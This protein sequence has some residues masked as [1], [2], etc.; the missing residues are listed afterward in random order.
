LG[1]SP[2]RRRSR[3]RQRVPSVARNRAAFGRAR[4]GETDCPLSHALLRPRSTSR[5][6]TWWFVGGRGFVPT[7][8]PLASQHEEPQVRAVVTSPL[9]HCTKC[10]VT[11]ISPGRW[12]N[13]ARWSWGE[14]NPRP[15]AGERTRYDHSR[16]RGCRSLTGGSVGHLTLGSGG[17]RPVF[18]W[19]QPSFRPSVV[20]PTVIS[21]FCCRAAGDRPRVALLLTMSLRS[22]EIQAARANCSLAILFGAPFYESE[23]LG[24]HAR[25]ALLTSKPVSPV[26]WN[27][28]AT[29][30]PPGQPRG[31][32]G[33]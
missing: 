13:L 18:P 32:R 9:V 4:Q 31:F 1:T 5:A 29:G 27:D 20:F 23:Q 16:H 21:R 17:P 28:Q 14:S 2:H 7:A 25:P 8:F 12:H 22:P 3:S 10:Y 30:P 26:G 11:R 33:V 24:S 19:R 6:L 15:S